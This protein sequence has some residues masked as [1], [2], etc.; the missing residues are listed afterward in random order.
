MKKSKE[1]NS[2]SPEPKRNETSSTS[3]NIKSISINSKERFK[4]S[5]LETKNLLKKEE[6]ENLYR[7]NPSASEGPPEVYLHRNSKGGVYIHEKDIEGLFRFIDPQGFGTITMQDIKKRVSSFAREMTTRDY[8]FLMS[9]KNTITIRELM[10]ILEYNE[11]EDFDPVA[12]A[13]KFFD[14]EETGYVDLRK[15]KEIFKQL[16]YEELTQGDLQ[17]LVECADADLDGK[18]CLE[19]FRRLIPIHEPEEQ[20]PKNVN[21]VYDPQ[22]HE[23][24][25]SNILN[26][27]NN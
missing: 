25:K 14:P 6:P 3:K 19:D 10:E 20:H 8:K 11:L 2:R 24:F 12:E 15:L 7:T 13:F 5:N 9:G 22:V 1:L 4:P 21:L 23:Q 18:I 16:G 26:L 27:G 17:I